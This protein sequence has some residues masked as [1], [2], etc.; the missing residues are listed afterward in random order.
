MAAGGKAECLQTLER[1]GAIETAARAW[2][3]AGFTAEQ[4]YSADADYSP[5]AWLVHKTRVTKGCAAG[6]LGWARRTVT[7]LEAVAAL[8]EGGALSESMARVICGWTDKLPADCRPA[9]DAILVAAGAG[10]LHL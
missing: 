8:A 7:H 10:R 9:A 3:L 1:L 4:G 5:R 2:I 6:H